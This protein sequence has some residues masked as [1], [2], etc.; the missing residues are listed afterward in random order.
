MIRDYKLSFEIVP[1]LPASR[2]TEKNKFE[3]LSCKHRI[4]GKIKLKVTSRIA[5][6]CLESRKKLF[7][8]ILIEIN[9]TVKIRS[10]KLESIEWILSYETDTYVYFITTNVFSQ[11]I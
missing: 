10:W 5:L 4:L 8:I 7:S 1:N 2:L 6:R 3:Y 9:K 11:N